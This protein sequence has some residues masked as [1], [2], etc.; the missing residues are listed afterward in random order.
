MNCN[1]RR[2]KAYFL[3]LAHLFI[4]LVTCSMISVIINVTATVSNIWTMVAFIFVGYF[5]MINF[6]MLVPQICLRKS[7]F[8]K[9][10]LD[11]TDIRPEHVF[12]K[13]AAG[14]VFIYT[15]PRAQAAEIHLV[16]VN[17]RM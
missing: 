10:T 12:S 14:M 5:F 1:V 3:F 8:A 2:L 9:V 17:A 4:S 11:D 7:F 13:M 16:F 6:F 15:V